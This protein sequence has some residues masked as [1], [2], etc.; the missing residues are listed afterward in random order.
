MWVVEG[1]EAASLARAS[2]ISET[3]KKLRSRQA[4][5]GAQN[6]QISFITMKR[7]QGRLPCP[8]CLAA[9]NSCSGVRAVSD[10][11][12]ASIPAAR[13][14]ITYSASIPYGFCDRN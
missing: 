5:G 10:A 7:N 14:P 3:T 1:S 6:D 12:Q 2:G 13:A 4:V 8:F 9:K 11:D